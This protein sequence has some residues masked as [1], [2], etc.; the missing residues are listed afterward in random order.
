[1]CHDREVLGDGATK[2][3]F[4]KSSK[5][6]NVRSKG[7]ESDLKRNGGATHACMLRSVGQ[8]LKQQIVFAEGCSVAN[9]RQYALT[10]QTCVLC[11]AQ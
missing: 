4:A 9:V 5:N 1:M 2:V 10:L 7:T 11:C 3:R 6:E 8:N